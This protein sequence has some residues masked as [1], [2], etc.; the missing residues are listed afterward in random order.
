MNFISSTTQILMCILL[1]TSISEAIKWP[2]WPRWSNLTSDL[3]SVT[4]INLVF[5]CI[6]LQTAFL[7]ASEAN[8]GLWGHGG[9]QI[10][11]EITSDH[12]IELGDLNYLCSHVFL[13]SKGLHELNATQAEEEVYDPLTCVASPQA[14]TDHGP[15]QGVWWKCTH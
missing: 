4:L 8:G 10:T 5:M 13:A 3:K 15:T 11:S 1:L 14:K 7:V 12:G 9:L 6:L 2:W